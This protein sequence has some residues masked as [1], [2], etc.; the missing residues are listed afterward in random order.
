[1]GKVD[2]LNIRMYIAHCQR[3]ETTKNKI[4]TILFHDYHII[5]L[6]NLSDTLHWFYLLLCAFDHYSLANFNKHS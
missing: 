3:M 6:E 4:V 5:G 1:M 2:D